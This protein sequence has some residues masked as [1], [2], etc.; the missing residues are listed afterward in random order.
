[1]SR[2][3]VN[4]TLS[5]K[6]REHLIQTLD[7]DS[8][9]FQKN[10]EVSDYD[11]FISSAIVLGSVKCEWIEKSTKLQWVQLPSVGFG[12]LLN[13]VDSPILNQVRICN[14]AGFFEEQVSETILAAL[15]SLGRGIIPLA[16]AQTE[17][18]WIKE[19]IR[20][21]L[22]TLFN[23][24]VLLCGYGSINQKL[25]SLLKPFRCEILR[26]A[27]TNPKADIHAMNELEG[28]LGEQDVVISSLPETEETIGLFDQK[29]L[30][31]L[32]NTCVFVNVGRGSA[33]DEAALV[34][35]LQHQKLKAAILDVTEKEP[36]PVDSPLWQ[37]PNLLLTQHSAGGSGDEE[38]RKIK[39][40]LDN[41][42]RFKE[43]RDLV[44]VVDFKKGY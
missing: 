42:S 11:A 9:Y 26:F 21:E 44:S 29:R 6:N 39:F 35:S 1:M 37:C 5:E 19:G 38:D 10:E 27:K 15:L 22:N 34:D 2:I 16:K 24:K 41:Y 31:M 4:I 33:V 25:E 36:L 30:S 32:K 40:F 20:G 28:S 3:Y 43:K 7:E 18:G 17:K 8:L 12:S 13:L 23:K 14:L